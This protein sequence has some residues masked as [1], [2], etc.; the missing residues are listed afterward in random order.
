MQIP[1]ERLPIAYLELLATLIGLASFASNY[2]KTLIRLNTD[3]SDVVTWLNKG[4]CRAGIGFRLRSA[5]EFIK[6]KR[7]IKLRAFHIKGEHNCS[8]D[9][10]SRG[11]IAD[12]LKKSGKRIYHK[13]SDVYRLASNPMVA[14]QQSSN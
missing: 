12:W 7:G 8:A 14:W 13:I 3:N 6:R 4:R 11:T 9:A 10:L 1:T 2:P 5:I